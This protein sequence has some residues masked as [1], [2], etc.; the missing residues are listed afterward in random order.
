MSSTDSKSLKVCFQAGRSSAQK[1]L[2]EKPLYRVVAREPD[3]F[4]WLLLAISG[5]LRGSKDHGHAAAV[6]KDE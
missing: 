4:G 2:A 6:S 5:I 3:R 1:T